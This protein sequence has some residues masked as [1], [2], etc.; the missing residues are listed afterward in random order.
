MPDFTSYV[1]PGVYVSDTSQPV[2]T[3][4]TITTSTVT[5][6][7]PAQGYQTATDLVQVYW[8]TNTALSHRG[9][10]TTAVTGP[11]AIG[12]PVV[13]TAAGV[14]LVYNV[15]YQWTVDTSGGGGAANAV[16]Y[17]KRLGTTGT[18]SAPSPTAGSVDGDYFSV[19]Y[20]YADPTYYSPQIFADPSLIAA[21]YGAAVTSTVPTNPNATQVVCPLTLAAQLAMLNGAS[22]VLCLP[23]NPSDG[24]LKAQF[25]AAYAKV[26]ADY[27][28]MLV[29]PLFVDATPQ[30]DTTSADA[31]SATAV[32]ALV[33]DIAA[34]CDST[35]AN[36]YGRMAFVGL[37]TNYDS[38]TRPFDQLATTIN[39]KRVVLGYPNQLAFY[40]SQLSQ[41][42]TISGYYLAAAMAGRLAG[43]D[44][45]QGLTTQAMT[46]FNGFPAVLAQAQTKA[47]K[48]TLSKSGVAVAE[49][50][51]TGQMKI[52]HGVTTRMASIEEREINIVRSGDVL[53]EMVQTGMDAAGLIGQPIDA[54]MTTKVKGA[55]SGILEL[56]VNSKVIQAYGNLAVRQ[57][58]LPSGDPS[59]IECQ[60]A[61]APAVPLNY[62]LATFA[63]DLNSGDFTSTNTAAA[64]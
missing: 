24:T 21:T 54:N 38:T 51:R 30:G 58:A 6:I 44:A 17:I 15:D 49:I 7:G 5:V 16:T 3:P 9:I 14:L 25:L 12:A 47:F 34:H 48:D 2:V 1:P 23:T 18:P 32:L 19:T 59:I 55:L 41:T 37:E 29:V 28:A 31:H 64:A 36:G 33:Q 42:T 57:R 13:K 63:I 50:S 4:T 43:L 22:S 62:I 40:N 11:P 27:R 39:D 35:A 56:A 46:G 60:F 10:F 61:Y 26:A 8:N 45:D 52:R 20:N 53:F